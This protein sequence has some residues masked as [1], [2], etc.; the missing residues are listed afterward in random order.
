MI[1]EKKAGKCSKSSAGVHI[2]W[3]LCII[4]IVLPGRSVWE[5]DL[6]KH[7]YVC[8]WPDVLCMCVCHS[9]SVCMIVCINY[10]ISYT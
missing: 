5:E 3:D 2:R 7:T 9:T 6:C 8:T 1:I 4:Y 10:Y